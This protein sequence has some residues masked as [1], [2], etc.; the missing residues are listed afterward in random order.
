MRPGDR[1][2]LVLTEHQD[3]SDPTKPRISKVLLEDVRVLATDQ[4]TEDPDFKP[5]IANTVTLEVSL[6]DAQ[7]IA[8]GLG[9]GQHFAGAAQCLWR[10]GCQHK[11]K[12]A[13][14]EVKDK[15]PEL[16]SRTRRIVIFR[17]AKPTEYTCRTSRAAMW[18]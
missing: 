1:V 10:R 18:N 3:E 15:Q 7:K 9:C 13:K 11:G 2:D 6:D 5:S 17:S 8:L 14:A 4:R 16:R 12:P